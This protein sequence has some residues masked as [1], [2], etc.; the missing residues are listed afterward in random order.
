MNRE[1]VVQELM[2]IIRQVDRTVAGVKLTE[3]HSLVKDLGFDSLKIGDF[4]A[5]A[6]ACFPDVD[7]TPWFVQNSEKGTDTIGSLADIGYVVNAFAADPFQVP[8]GAS[9]AATT[10]IPSAPWEMLLPGA[11]VLDANGNATVVRRP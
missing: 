8:N 10:S 4:I 7:L 2:Q 6:E 3:S 11:V 1:A 9:A 5:R